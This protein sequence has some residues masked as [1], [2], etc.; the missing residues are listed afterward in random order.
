M[1]SVLINAVLS[2]SP[3]YDVLFESLCW[4]GETCWPETE[5]VE[6]LTALIERLGPLLSDSDLSPITD[7]KKRSIQEKIESVIWSK[8]LPFLYRI[9]VE[10]DDETRSRESTAAACRLLGACVALCEE[11]VRR[12]VVLSALRSFQRSED[13]LAQ[14]NLSEQVSAEV[15]AAL[16]PFV[17]ADEQLTSSTLNSVLSCVRSLPDASLLSRIAVRVILTL[18]NCCSGERS[19]R[20]LKCVLDDVC[21][22]HSSEHSPGATERALLC[23]T[24]LSDHFL[25]PRGSPD[26]RVSF[27]FWRVV[28]DGLVHRDG[29]SRKRALF[30]LKRCAALSEEEGLGCPLSA[31]EEGR[32]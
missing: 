23:F 24:V 17:A 6:A 15:L 28:Q 9:S 22:W 19:A 3:D 13:E 27:Q 7:A 31:S 4:P 16:M 18:L 1:Y 2:S 8:C 5:R 12:R 30:L 25:Q 26:P 10:A 11:K 29:V 21:G 32:K 14:G 20:I